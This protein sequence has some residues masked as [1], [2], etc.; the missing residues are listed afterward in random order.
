MDENLCCLKNKE[1]NYA[2][3]NSTSCSHT[4]PETSQQPPGNDLLL[5][6]KMYFPSS[7]QVV[8]GGCLLLPS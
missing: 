8:A 6:Q 3:N 2:D 4:G 1:K 7:W 5:R